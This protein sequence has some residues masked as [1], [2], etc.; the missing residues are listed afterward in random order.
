MDWLVE[1]AKRAVVAVLG[2]ALMLGWWTLTGD[3]V[4]ETPA[5]APLPTQPTHL[6]QFLMA[7]RV[8]LSDWA[9]GAADPDRTPNPLPVYFAPNALPDLR[10]TASPS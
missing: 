6:H 4:H 3:E 7:H 10:R 8:F 5:D 2:T 1:K 9:S